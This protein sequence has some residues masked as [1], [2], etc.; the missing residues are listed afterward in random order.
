LDKRVQPENKKGVTVSANPLNLL[1]AVFGF[2][3]GN[4]GLQEET[5]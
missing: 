3:P 1:K 5:N 4:K 2:E